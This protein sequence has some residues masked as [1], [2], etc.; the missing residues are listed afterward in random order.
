MVL[1][2]PKTTQ[3]SICG[4]LILF[5]LGEKASLLGNWQEQVV[6]ITFRSHLQSLFLCYKIGSCL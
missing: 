5:H 2:N 1:R 3:F 4:H 6:A